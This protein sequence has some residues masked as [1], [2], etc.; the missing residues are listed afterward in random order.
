MVTNL[1]VTFEPVSPAA[2]VSQLAADTVVSGYSF[3]TE[4]QKE[5][6]HIP[7]EGDFPVTCLFYAQNDFRIYVSRAAVEFY[8]GG[9]IPAELAA[10]E[11]LFYKRILETNEFSVRRW[12]AT[13]EGW[14]DDDEPFVNVIAEGT[15]ANTFPLLTA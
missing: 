1:Y 3:S 2:D 15:S 4:P 13:S 10:G 8:R 14:D 7:D 9:V 12:L 6:I 11:T 5:T